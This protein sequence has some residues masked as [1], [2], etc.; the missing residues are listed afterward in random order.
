V[1]QAMVVPSYPRGPLHPYRGSTVEGQNDFQT[2][3][4]INSRTT[5]VLN[6]QPA[7]SLRFAPDPVPASIITTATLLE[8]GI[9]TIFQKK[10][11]LISHFIWVSPPELDLN[12]DHLPSTR[13]DSKILVEAFE[14]TWM[15]IATIE[16]IICS[17]FWAIFDSLN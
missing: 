15:R 9:F 11:N 10:T 17:I 4:Q 1:L 5:N 14:P 13:E 8:Q 12:K 3:P 6:V 2:F 7:S 16:R